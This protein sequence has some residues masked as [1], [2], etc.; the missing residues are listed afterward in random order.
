MWSLLLIFLAMCQCFKEPVNSNDR[1]HSTE[2]KARMPEFEFSTP[3]LT[4]FDLSYSTC[5]INQFS[6]LLYTN[7]TYLIGLSWGSSSYSLKS[8]D[9][10]WAITSPACLDI[11]K[12]QPTCQILKNEDKMIG[13]N[14]NKVI[15]SL[16]E[17][18][19]KLIVEINKIWSMELQTEISIVKERISILKRH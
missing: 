14:T 4:H 13:P 10:D 15:C 9:S 8:L 12:S 18:T 19:D 5:A 16:W 17:D 1:H 3:Q 6:L 7:R 2:Q 11:Y